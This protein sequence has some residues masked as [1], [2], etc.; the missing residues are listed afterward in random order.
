MVDDLR[1][2]PS[3]TRN[4]EQLL[5]LLRD[6]IL[7]EADL[8]GIVPRGPSGVATDLHSPADPRRLNDSIRKITTG[9]LLPVV[10][11]APG[12]TAH[13]ADSRRDAHVAF[14]TATDVV[15][16]L[17]KVEGGSKHFVFVSSAQTAATAL[18][19]AVANPG[20]GARPRRRRARIR[21]K[22]RER[23]Y[24]GSRRWRSCQGKRASTPEVVRVAVAAEMVRRDR[25]SCQGSGG[26][27]RTESA[28]VGSRRPLRPPRRVFKKVRQSPRL[29][30][31]PARRG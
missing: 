17:A 25:V 12:S 21:G 5:A 27:W 4:A 29:H 23:D 16:N 14:L 13:S 1:F 18:E 9:R 19:A 24:A 26:S 3:E 8:V 28:C 22:A 6:Q 30:N 15:R 11:P 7:T 31:F 20:R 2:K 10:E